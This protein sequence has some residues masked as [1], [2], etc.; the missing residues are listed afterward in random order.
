MY[1]M[2]APYLSTYKYLSII[3]HCRTII[4]YGNTLVTYVYKTLPLL[5][6]VVAYIIRKC[7]V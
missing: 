7:T 4:I 1:L 3:I 5:H 2:Y 6:R